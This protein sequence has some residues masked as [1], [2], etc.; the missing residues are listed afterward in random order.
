MMLIAG[1]L[2]SWTCA[3]DAVATPPTNGESFRVDQIQIGIEDQFRLGCWTQARVSIWSP[4]VYDNARV[5]IELPD[6]EGVQSVHITEGLMMP[7]GESQLV[8]NLKVGRADGDLAVRV[9]ADEELLG[10]K[11][12]SA[13]DVAS[14]VAGNQYIVVSLGED[15]GV[16]E[17]IA[18]R[19]EASEQRTVH[20]RVTEPGSLPR[21]WLGYGGVNL[22]V[23]PTSKQSVAAGMTAQQWSALKTWVRMG[24][25]VILS[26]GDESEPVLAPGS[27]AADLLPGIF[28]GVRLQRET[29]NFEGYA[30]KTRMSL[31]SY[32]RE[33]DASFRLPMAILDDIRGN[34]ELYEGLG[35]ERTPAI[36][37]SS[38][39]FGH[40][41]FLAV[42]LDLAPIARWKDGRRRI[43]KK[44]IDLC[45]GEE[46]RDD[47][48]GQYSQM[49]Q[50]GFSDLT[51][52]LRSALD[53]FSGSALVPFSW[54]ACLVGLYIVLIGPVDYFL[55]RR[56]DRRFSLTW[57]TFP[58][59]VFAACLLAV[60]LT[61]LWKG[62]A[63]ALN[64]ATV[65]DIDSQTGVLRGNTWGHLFSPVNRRYDISV[66]VSKELLPHA[67]LEGSLTSW[68]GLVGS[69]FGGM[70]SRQRQNSDLSYQIVHE[71]GSSV[72]SEVRK[73]PVNIYGSRSLH[74]ETWGL[75]DIQDVGKI[76]YDVDNQLSGTIN[77]P[78]PVPLKN[79]QLFFGRRVYSLPSLA[80][81]GSKNIS[82]ATAPKAI[83]VILTKKQVNQDLKDVSQPWDRKSFDVNRIM[84]MMMFHKAAGGKN[85]TS[86][87][88]RFQ[89]NLD[90]SDH[91]N[92][93]R[94]ILVGK[95]T[96]PGL[97][98][99]AEEGLKVNAETYIRVL[100]PVTK[101]KG[102]RGEARF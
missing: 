95:V 96:E 52:Q 54:I 48:L 14:G 76:S 37:R 60:W 58:L 36:I 21:E 85:Y 23:I 49:T 63:M 56:L 25:R 80:P 20:V 81:G 19:R 57:L 16:R 100:L 87:L 73:L 44:L 50:I 66:E 12:F 62:Q 82:E 7:S 68:Q 8:T 22:I 13:G 33:S 39:G 9:F 26:A 77:N 47:V 15:L 5:E 86:L 40:V 32:P 65:I 6:G 67:K 94:A 38:Y 41:I 30:G 1:T 31:S 102:R 75:A 101:S 99:L 84:Q 64:Q 24:G 53:Q 78:L 51:G 61:Q 2:P 42:D 55:L 17:T 10:E 28:D 3:Q 88:H 97:P 29:S 93:E 43:L 35:S 89:G 69:A 46:K 59:G 79:C 4:R 91:L 34:V 45:L 71:N 90:F 98:L 27:A 83:E 74:G 70:N 18:M 11:T 92:Q 72:S